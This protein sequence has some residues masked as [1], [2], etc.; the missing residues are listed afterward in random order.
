MYVLWTNRR[1]V[2]VPEEIISR[3]VLMLK[4]NAVASGLGISFHTCL[5]LLFCQSMDVIAIRPP[6]GSVTEIDAADIVTTV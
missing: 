5:F 1:D 4:E 6:S 3:L 2:I